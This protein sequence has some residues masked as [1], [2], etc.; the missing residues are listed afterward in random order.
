MNL[1]ALPLNALRAFE[2]SAR[3]LNFT[4]AA[5]ELCVTQGAI[6]HQVR[7]LEQILGVTLFRRLPRGLTLTEE[8][9]ALWPA[10][11]R[12]F[13]T[14][15]DLLDQ[16]REGATHRPLT[17]GVVNT[18]AT[19]WLL[20]RL[21]GFRTAHP[22]VDLRLKTHNNKVNLAIEGLDLAIQFGDG[23]WPGLE[24]AELARGALSPL[25]SPKLARALA[26]PAD[27][28]VLPLLRSYRADEWPRWCAAA[29]APPPPLKGP[30]F[31]SSIAMAQ[32]AEQSMGVALVP[33]ALFGYELRGGRLVQPFDLAVDTGGYYLTRLT[34]RTPT[35]A[36]QAFADWCLDL[37]AQGLPA[38]A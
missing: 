27:L 5:D 17:V 13:E 26:S 3:H 2:A 31:D 30:V 9:E 38:A 36:M 7:A 24:A 12:S 25:C 22:F 33:P 16:V 34:S 20:P 14:I 35:P 1:S 4:R 10:V 6:S 23:H 29:G 28:A 19:G 11:S 32:A 18:F 37:A 21:E 15:G 8:G